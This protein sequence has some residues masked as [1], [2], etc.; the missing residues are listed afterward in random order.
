MNYKEW[1]KSMPVLR[2]SEEAV[3]GAAWKTCKKE[4]LKILHKH[5]FVHNQYSDESFIRP[6]SINE[7]EKL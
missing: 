6:E 7:I 4:V 2:I 3:A 5:T 1:Y